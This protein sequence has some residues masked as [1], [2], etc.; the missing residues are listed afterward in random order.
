MKKEIEKINNHSPTIN[1][2]TQS[3]LYTSYSDE[4]H[5]N[6][7]KNLNHQTLDSPCMPRKLKRVK[8]MNFLSVQK[9][10]AVNETDII[11]KPCYS[12]HN[13]RSD[14]VMVAT[15]SDETFSF[16]Q[17]QNSNII[18]TSQ[19][20]QSDSPCSYLLSVALEAYDF[21]NYDFNGKRFSTFDSVLD[22][23]KETT[24]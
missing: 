3:Y 9:Y 19:S 18:Y 21:N 22:N 6:N 2:F 13:S 14:F 12:D 1:T 10:I 24:L 20:T 5:F 23:S 7:N 4:A 16:L 11:P 15:D 8:D 17:G